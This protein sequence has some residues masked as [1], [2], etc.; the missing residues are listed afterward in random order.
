MTTVEEVTK[1]VITK[2]TTSSIT[3]NP[4]VVPKKIAIKY[5]P[6]ILGFIFFHKK[7]QKR[8][9]LEINIQEQLAQNL[10]PIDICNWIYATYGDVVNI[11]TYS[12]EQIVR[13]I[14]KIID[15]N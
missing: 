15:K 12:Q 3:I 7:N 4:N 10:Q 1:T 5:E 6:P 2:T 9:L 13:M 8:Y 11:T 14:N